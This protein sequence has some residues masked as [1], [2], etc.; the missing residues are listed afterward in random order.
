MEKLDPVTFCKFRQAC[1]L[2]YTVTDNKKVILDLQKYFCT[3]NKHNPLKFGAKYSILEIITDAPLSRSRVDLEYYL[4][5]SRDPK[6]LKILLDR[7]KFAVCVAHIENLDEFR[8]SKM[9]IIIMRILQNNWTDLYKIILEMDPYKRIFYDYLCK[10]RDYEL[11]KFCISMDPLYNWSKHL[12][13]E[14]FWDLRL[15][16]S[17]MLQ[18]FR[19]V[20][21]ICGLVD[22]GYP[23]KVLCILDNNCEYEYIIN[24]IESDTEDI[25]L[26]YILIAIELSGK[27]GILRH[28]RTD[29][30]LPLEYVVQVNTVA[31]KKIIN[32]ELYSHEEILSCIFKRDD[33]DLFNY[34][35]N[36]CYG[37][38][39]FRMVEIFLLNISG[40]KILTDILETKSFIFK[41][42]YIRNLFLISGSSRMKIILQKYSDI[43]NQL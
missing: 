19:F 8:N 17:K 4:F 42:V 27:W 14:N 35:F 11:F 3:I 30:L 10:L 7:L 36:S 41:S 29:N 34:F 28:L 32:L 12:H 26:G 24:L 40:T 5:L 37:L 2:F 18:F 1:K 23:H 38:D 20:T 39:L 31:T 15:Y 9:N 22:P 33:L 25:N 16:N 43:F 6:I 21:N 13:R